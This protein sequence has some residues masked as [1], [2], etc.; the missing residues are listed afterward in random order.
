VKGIPVNCIR[1]L[2]VSAC[3]TVLVAFV[4]LGRASSQE[5]NAEL[6]E[7][8]K[9]A[10]EAYLYAFPMIMNYGSMYEFTLDPKSSQYKGPFNQISNT[11]RVFTPKDT[12]VVTPNSDTPYSLLSMNLRAEP[13]VLCVPAVEKDR[14]YSVQL[15]DLYT[16]NFGYIGS[17]STGNGAGCYLVASPKWKGEIP[18]GIDKVFRCE[19]EF[20]FAIYRTQLFN[21]ADLDNVKKVQAG[22]KA[23]PLSAFLKTEP[24]AIDGFGF[25]K[26]DKKAAFG[27]DFIVYLNFLLQFCPANDAE[28][29]VRERFAKIGVGAGKPFDFQA[30]PADK[31]EALGRSIKSAMKKIE[32]DRAS[33]GKNENGWLVSLIAN[34]RQTINGNWTKRAAIALAGI[35]ANDAVEALYPMLSH[36]SDGAKPDTDKHRYTLTFAKDQLPPVKAFWSVTMY[37]AKTQLLIENPINRYL[38]NAPML[39]D[40]KRNAD[41]SLTLYI[42]KDSPGKDKEANWLPAPDGDPYL[43][44]RLYWPREDALNGK[45]LPPALKRVAP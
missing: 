33:F 29:P 39:P 2:S 7:Y 34:N 27:T 24:P 16:S 23:M 31:K 21:P 25:P 26:F 22:Y 44:M 12:V 6:A 5:K 15:I 40:L 11:A 35:Y 42:Q 45:W 43:V 38:I 9:I 10:E 30:L 8:E 18:K 4:L 32:V 3:A 13:M 36:D 19:T 20:A 14:Y 37:D 41:G 28:R 1:L 17:R